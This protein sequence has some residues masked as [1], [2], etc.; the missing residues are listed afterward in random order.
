MSADDVQEVQSSLKGSGDIGVIVS[1]SG[2]TKNAGR[3]LTNNGLHIE[4]VDLDGL[5]NIWLTHYERLSEPDRALLRLQPVYF[6]AD[7]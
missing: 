4:L 5:M 1:A 6:L 7:G 3:V 2:F